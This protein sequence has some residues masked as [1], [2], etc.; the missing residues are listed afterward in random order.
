VTGRGAPFLDL[1]PVEGRARVALRDDRFLGRLDA[2]DLRRD[3]D[4]A[5]ILSGLSERGYPAVSLRIGVEGEEHR[6]RVLAPGLAAP[7]VDLRVAESSALFQGPPRL[8]LG[9]E[10]LSF[11]AVISLV[12]QDP[13]AEYAADRPR[14]PGQAHPGLGRFVRVLDRLRAW[15]EDWGKDGLVAFPPHFHVAVWLGR[16]LRFVSPRRQG[17]FEALRRDLAALRLAEA[18]WAVEQGRVADET[19]QAARWEP[20]EMVAPLAPDLR[21]YLESEAYA[22]AVGEARDAARFRPGSPPRAEDESR[23]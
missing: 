14:M 12:L 17:R 7:L 22:R 20:G 16:S 21:G 18:S 23:R 9:L 10:V 8:P 15:A 11:L 13:R 3:L 5:G 2:A 4:E 1:R 6:L 19:G